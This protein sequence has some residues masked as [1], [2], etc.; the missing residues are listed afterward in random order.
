MRS[1]HSKSKATASRKSA[2]PCSYIRARFQNWDSWRQEL[3]SFP[4]VW[5]PNLSW[6][7]LGDHGSLPVRCQPREILRARED[8]RTTP[9]KVRS[10]LRRRLS[11]S[12]ATAVDVRSFGVI[13]VD[14]RD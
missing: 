8:R 5:F 10:S 7:R 3:F 4:P 2:A 14:I 13:E 12:H 1:R 11:Q 9:R 6:R